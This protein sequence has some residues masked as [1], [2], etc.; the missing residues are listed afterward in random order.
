MLPQ[1]YH[2]KPGTLATNVFE[3][4]V[5]P[6]H[7]LQLPGACMEVFCVEKLIQQEQACTHLPQ[8]FHPSKRVVQIPQFGS[9]VHQHSISPVFVY[10]L[11]QH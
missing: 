11:F 6:R 5:G 4:S 10:E 3:P 8:L 9:A 1:Y 2:D 7:E